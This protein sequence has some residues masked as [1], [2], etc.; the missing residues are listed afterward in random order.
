MALRHKIIKTRNALEIVW[1]GQ[2]GLLGQSPRD[3]SLQGKCNISICWDINLCIVISFLQNFSS[4]AKSRSCLKTT[5]FDG[6]WFRN[7][8]VW[9]E[10]QEGGREW[11][12]CSRGMQNNENRGEA[13]FLKIA[14]GLQFRLVRA[15]APVPLP[16]LRAPGRWENCGKKGLHGPSSAQSWQGPHAKCEIPNTQSENRIPKCYRKHIHIYVYIQPLVR[17]YCFDLVRYL[18]RSQFVPLLKKKMGISIPPSYTIHWIYE[19]GMSVSEISSFLSE[20]QGV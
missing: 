3:R 15:S 13:I 20:M 11:L 9:W 17:I 14:C 16:L 2:G 18:L 19:N 7:L 10:L 5:D 1:R 4:R 12:V 8:S 6:F